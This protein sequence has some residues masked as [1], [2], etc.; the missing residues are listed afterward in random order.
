VNDEKTEYSAAVEK[1]MS[2]EFLYVFGYEDPT[3][4]QVNSD[5][6]TDYQSSRVIRI[7]ARDEEEAL[8]WEEISPKHLSK[9]STATIK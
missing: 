9:T 3:D 1:T 8:E 7:L 4:R 5:L 2:H 6:D